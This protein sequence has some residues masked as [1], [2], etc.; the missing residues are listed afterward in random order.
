MQRLSYYIFLF[1]VYLFGA[2]PFPILYIVSFKVYVLLYYVIGYRK[3]VVYTNLAKAF[4]E[5]TD[6]ERKI[7]AKK[8]Y[9]HLA[10]IFLESLKGF[11][12]SHSEIVKR[13]RVVN[14]DIIDKYMNNGGTV[15]LI[16]GHYGNWE[17]GSMSGGLQANCP[18]VIFYKPLSNKLINN[19]MIKSRSRCGTIM[20]SIDKTYQAFKNQMGKSSLFL[21]IADQSPSRID[22]AYWVN[23]L[24]IETAFLHGPELYSRKLKYPSYFVDI[25]RVKRSYYEMELIPIAENPD[26][27]SEGEIT[28]RYAKLLE[29]RIRKEPEFWLWS[30]RRWKHTKQNS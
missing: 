2:L 10:D 27:L 8:F 19:Y 7:I 24:G 18:L 11:S 30:H 16:G 17:W 26:D 3:K 25:K 21:L 20:A 9:K 13:H 28:A 14:I 15:T 12:M 23:F 6:K 5:K 1:F 4:P 22:K 29:A